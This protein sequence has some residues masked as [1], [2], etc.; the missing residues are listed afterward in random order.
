MILLEK[1]EY[2]LSLKYFSKSSVLLNYREEKESNKK[3]FSII[4]KAKIEHDIEQFEY[5]ASKSD[6]GIKF[7][8]LVKQ[9]KKIASEIDWPSDSSLINLNN[10]LLYTSPSPR[11]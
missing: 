6:D 7:I 9:Y 5:L 3:R 8:D 11:D 1:K 4:S 2:D 10:C